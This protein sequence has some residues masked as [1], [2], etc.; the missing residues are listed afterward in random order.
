MVI[1]SSIDYQIMSCKEKLKNQ[2]YEEYGEY[3]VSPFVDIKVSRPWYSLSPEHWE[4]IVELSNNRGRHIYRLK[5]G[6]FFESVS[7]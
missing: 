5:D 2:L 6:F 4:Y 1:S 3:S 7:E